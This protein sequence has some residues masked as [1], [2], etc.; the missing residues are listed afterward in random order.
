M[1]RILIIEDN[2]ANRELIVYLLNAFHHIPLEAVD[3]EAG[4]DAA[5]RE[6]P[7]LILCDLQ[8]PKIDGYTLARYFKSDQIL[9][10]IPLVAVTASS[11]V[12]DREKIIS[13]GFNGYISKP[14][15]PETFVAKVETFLR[16]ETDGN[17]PHR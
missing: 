5:H 8:L 10:D 16:R 6:R 11:M 14:I 13:A 4:L 7:D 15:D 17:N 3:G 9:R 2:L 1:A 12:G